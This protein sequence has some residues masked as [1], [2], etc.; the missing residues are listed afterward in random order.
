M[1]GEAI[2]SAS[3]QRVGG[4]LPRKISIFFAEMATRHFFCV[5]AF[6]E[7]DGSVF[8]NCR[9]NCPFTGVNTGTAVPLPVLHR[10]KGKGKWSVRHSG[11]FPNDAVKRKILHVPS[12]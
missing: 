5:T 11:T 1:E 10:V 4:G 6:L 9:K 12:F 8:P 2:S 3:A 7:R